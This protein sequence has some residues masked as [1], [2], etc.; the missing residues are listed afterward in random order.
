MKLIEREKDGEWREK[1]KWNI[2]LRKKKQMK[3]F[4]EVMIDFFDLPF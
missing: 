2:G 3:S 4:H 1:S